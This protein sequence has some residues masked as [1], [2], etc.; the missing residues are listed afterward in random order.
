MEH[1][2]RIQFLAT[3]VTQAARGCQ[4]NGKKGQNDVV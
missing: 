3:Q 1:H 2:P 4:G